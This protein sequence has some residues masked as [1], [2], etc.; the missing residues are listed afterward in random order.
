MLVADLD[1]AAE[2][3]RPGFTGA[4]LD[5]GVRAVFALP[6]SLS[7]QCVAALSL[8]RVR[9]GAL[10]ASGLDGGLLAA[11]LAALPLLD[12][13]AEH[14]ATASAEG[15]QDEDD[16]GQLAARERV[17]VYQAT[18]MIICALDV[19]PAEAL[20]RL[21]AQAFPRGL[22]ATG[23]AREVVERRVSVGAPDWQDPD[24][25]ARLPR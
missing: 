3:R 7:S 9:P 10:S 12:V 22:T 19:A 15:D 17:E 23:L 6:V 25:P 14:R 8:Y 24:A 11:E 1:D 13:I 2:L 16:S 18:G 21:R 5:A 4:V 20:V